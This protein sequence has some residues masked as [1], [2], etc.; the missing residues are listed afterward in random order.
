MAA[1]AIS[2]AS[3]SFGLVTVPVRLYAATE[4]SAGLHFNMLHAK[5]GARLHQQL[6][7]SAD[8][9]VVPRSEVVKGYEFEKGRYV[10]LTDEELKALEERTTR[11]IEIEEFVP[12]AS[13]D[14]L[15]FEKPYYLSPDKG[16]ERPF[17]LLAKALEE[18]QL[19]AVGQYAARGKDYLVAVRPSQGRL[20]MHQLLHQD[21]VRPIDEVPA[22]DREVRPPELKLARELIEHLKAPAFDATRYVDHV[23]QRV[24]ELIERKVKGEEITASAEPQPRGNVID[25][26]EALKASLA[27]RQAQPPA[28]ETKSQQAPKVAAGGERHAPKRAAS[29][30]GSRAPKAARTSRKAG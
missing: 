30:T 26:M 29:R 23:R 19:A 25:L 6:V 4:V 18:M 20:V 1:R 12:L 21:E 22:A 24:R 13:V 8:G 17:A 14:P 10:Q 28:N 27:R 9:E 16:G 7:C 11:G 2:T 15:Y 5:D 3:I